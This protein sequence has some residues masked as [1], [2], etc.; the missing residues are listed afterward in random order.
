MTSENE[1]NKRNRLNIVTTTN[2]DSNDHRSQAL[3]WIGRHENSNTRKTYTSAFKQFESW[4]DEKKIDAYNTDDA[5]KKIST[6]ESQYLI[7]KY[8]RIY[9]FGDS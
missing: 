5:T 9:F 6:D 3:A 4:C 7:N 1:A 2:S 8:L